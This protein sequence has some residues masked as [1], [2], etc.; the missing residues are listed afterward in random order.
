MTFGGLHI[1]PHPGQKSKLDVGS[2][3]G[4]VISEDLRFP[5]SQG[6]LPGSLSSLGHFGQDLAQLQ[7]GVYIE[8]GGARHRFVVFSWLPVVFGWLPVG[9]AQEAQVVLASV[10]QSEIVLWPAGAAFR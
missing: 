6:R 4:F 2:A 10:F 3:P 1:T 9:Q 8:T 7:P 5:L